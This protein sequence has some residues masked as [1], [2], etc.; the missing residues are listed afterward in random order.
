MTFLNGFIFCAGFIFVAILLV[1]AWFVLLKWSSGTMQAHDHFQNW[2]PHKNWSIQVTWTE[3][4][5]TGKPFLARSVFQCE[6]PDMQAA[7]KI[8]EQADWGERKN[9]KFGSILPGHHTIF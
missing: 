9:V 8:A 1:V 7:Y 5:E 2:P 3:Y 6:A 4:N